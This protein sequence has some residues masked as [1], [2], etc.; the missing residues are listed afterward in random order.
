M[1]ASS[2]HRKPSMTDGDL[3]ASHTFPKLFFGFSVLV[4]VFFSPSRWKLVRA[5]FLCFVFYF[6]FLAV[7]NFAIK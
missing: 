2:Q 7:V 6:D 5:V 3:N 1:V 4:K